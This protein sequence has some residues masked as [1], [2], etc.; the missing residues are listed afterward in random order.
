MK[1]ICSFK[2]LSTCCANVLIDILR[3]CVVAHM[4]LVNK[5][6]LSLTRISFFFRTNIKELTSEK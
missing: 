6:R 4:V 3:R 1:N 5:S 2:M